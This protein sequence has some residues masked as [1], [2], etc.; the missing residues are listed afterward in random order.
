MPSTSEQYSEMNQSQPTREPRRQGR[1][2]APNRFLPLSELLDQSLAHTLLVDSN[3]WQNMRSNNAFLGVRRVGK[4]QGLLRNHPN[5]AQY[6][7][8]GSSSSPKYSKI[9]EA[10]EHVLRFSDASNAQ[11]CVIVFWSKPSVFHRK[12]SQ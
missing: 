12:P 2:R 8:S 3:F 4:P 11:I 6:L 5:R 10:N 9:L 1:K 7:R